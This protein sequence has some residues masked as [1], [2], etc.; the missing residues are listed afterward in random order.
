MEKSGEEL[1]DAGTQTTILGLLGSEINGD[2]Q[3]DLK[4]LPPE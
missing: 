2:S 3:S 4:W 1:D